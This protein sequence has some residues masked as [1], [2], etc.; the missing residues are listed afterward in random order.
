MS[1]FSGVKNNKFYY[2]P[3]VKTRKN[4]NFLSDINNF[5]NIKPKKHNT[6]NNLTLKS[7]NQILHLTKSNSHNNITNG[8]KK[9]D[10]LIKDQDNNSLL[11]NLKTRSNSKNDK[12]K[13]VD[14]ESL[15]ERNIQL[16]TEINQIKKELLHMKA[17]N[18]RKDKE[19]LQK[20]KLLM[21]AFDK[22]NFD[23]ND[24]ESIINMDDKKTNEINI[25]DKV[26][27]KNNYMAKFK[28]QYNELKKK[29]EEKIN[30]VNNLKKN[31]KISKLN[32]LNI[33]I[34]EILK[35][36]NKLKELYI[37]LF[38]ENKKNL[39]KSKKINILENE[40]NDKNLIILQLQE[41]LKISSSTNIKYE[42]DIE[43]LKTTINNLETENKNLLDK[44]KKLYESYNKISSRKKEAERRGSKFLDLELYKEKRKSDLNFNNT[45]RSFLTLA[46]INT[47][48]RSRNFRNSV[49][50]TMKRKISPF[51][52]KIPVSSI[53]SNLKKSNNNDITNSLHIRKESNNEINISKE[54]ENSNNNNNN[55]N[56]IEEEN[57]N[58]N[59][60]LEINISFN[61]DIS[62]TSYILIKNF[63]A[64]KISKE[65]SL[66]IIIKPILNEISNEKQI[67][68]DILVSLFTNKVCECIN[69][70]KNNS[71][72]NS[73]S[74]LINS[75]L[76]DSKYELF[77]FI[78]AFL[79]MFDNVKIYTDNTNDEEG[80][81]KKI[82]ESLV[83][84]KEYFENS[85]K[86]KFISFSYFRGI[87]N[88]KNIILDDE[89]IEYLIYRMKRDCPNIIS[90]NSKMNKKE[91]IN[92]IDN[93][94]NNDRKEN[95]KK[96]ENNNKDKDNNKE[97]EN[98]NK[99]ENEDNKENK[100]INENKDINNGNNINNVNNT[101][102]K[103][104]VN[105]NPN[106]INSI[107]INL[108]SANSNNNNQK[109]EERPIKI[110][111]ISQEEDNN[112]N[113]D[114]ENKNENK[115]GEKPEEHIQ[116]SEE[117]CSI[118]D[119]NYKTFLNLI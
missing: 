69:C 63:E 35:E 107:I 42:N 14:N 31:I 73:I 45:N 55:N 11:L 5:K 83:Q 39:E 94:N 24:L 117:T 80:I 37:N 49:H 71:D 82:N 44:L 52:K 78:K 62:Q 103:N 116:E 9:S 111:N 81:V 43:E 74:N 96:D 60:N 61:N 90:K 89:A 53:N 92:D 30:E 13:Y 46:K 108:N 19:I 2:P 10:F 40:L 99:K 70:T 54:N 77:A 57:I 65:D 64:F 115:N 58:T 97:N 17:E 85:Y 12:Y 93:N 102:E 95:E 6:N 101:E 67:K 4:N 87:L 27:K 32:E 16:K 100:N 50:T 8:N 29:Y 20:D 7:I 15:Y 25:L 41:S 88:N 72:I 59:E 79:D 38:E 109:T 91:E 86:E 66:T 22:K 1:L 28:K 34:R 68:N 104:N 3:I 26:I 112:K 36:Y 48:I 18:Q 84:Y 105:N 114:I 118:F 21:N 98:N 51:S 106:N 119:L 33:Q 56:N 113:N 47:D 75:L 76:N 23:E 110:V